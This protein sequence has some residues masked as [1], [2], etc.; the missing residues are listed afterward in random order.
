MRI[1]RRA[2][3]RL[4][5]HHL[6]HP[7][8]EFALAVLAVPGDH[9]AV[10]PQNHHVHRHRRPQFLQ[11][12][13][14]QE[15]PGLLVDDSAGLRPGGRSL[16]QVPTLLSGAAPADREDGAAQGRCLGMLSRRGVE[17]FPEVADVGAQGRERIGLVGNR[18]HENP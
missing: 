12:L 15:L 9:G 10:Q 5:A 3:D 11:Q 7:G 14:A 17:A 13:V 18:R 6:A 16:D 2:D 8:Q 1:Q 4:L